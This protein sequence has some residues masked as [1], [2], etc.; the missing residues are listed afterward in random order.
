M[1]EEDGMIVGGQ[2][3]VDDGGDGGEAN[4]GS[5]FLGEKRGRRRW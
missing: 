5:G 4:G 2:G 1:R 3:G